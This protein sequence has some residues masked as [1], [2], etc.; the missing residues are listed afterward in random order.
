V[1]TRDYLIR[2]PRDVTVR[3][4][5]EDVRCESR[6]FGWETILDGR[7]A[8]GRAAIAWI[9]SGASGRTYTELPGGDVTV[10]RFA[11]GQRCFAE[12]RTRPSVFLAGGRRVASLG[13][14]IGDLDAHVNQLEDQLRKG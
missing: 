5:C 9:R 4:A 13:E 12:H 11:S 7:T 10:F 8:Q 1:R 14:W 3:A 6:Q 2:F